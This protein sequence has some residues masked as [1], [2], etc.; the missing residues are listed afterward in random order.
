[1]CNKAEIPSKISPFLQNAPRM[2]LYHSLCLWLLQIPRTKSDAFLM[3]CRSGGHR[4]GSFSPADVVKGPREPQQVSLV[5]PGSVTPHQRATDAEI[6]T[7]TPKKRNSYAAESDAN[8]ETATSR[9]SNGLTRSFIKRPSHP[10]K[11]VKEV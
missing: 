1:M 9:K 8:T 11:C 5:V 7:K 10:Q 4:H 2:P 3:S 6:Q